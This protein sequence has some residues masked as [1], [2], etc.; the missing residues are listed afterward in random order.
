MNHLFART[1]G[2]HIAA[3][4][5]TMLTS[6]AFSQPSNIDPV[7]KHSWSENVGWMNWADAGD[8][9]RA[10]GVY[11]FATFGSSA[12]AGY[13]WGENIGWV[14]FGDGSPTDGVSY[15]NTDSSDFGV[16]RDPFTGEL[17]GYAWSENVGWINFS[18]GAGASPPQPA[19]FVF[20][21]RRFRG[22]AWGENI[23]WINLD[24]PS[25]FVGL[26]CIADVNS[27]E[28]VDAIDYDT[29]VNA[30][31]LGV[32]LGDINLDGFVDAID[33]DTFINAWLNGC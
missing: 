21:D 20:E 6:L 18:G 17:S 3:A 2:R 12:L 31:L 27:D 23:G 1:A 8:P 29:F 19:R 11:V 30:W 15:S 7:K 28:F 5:S 32:P 10:S 33:Y 14:R 16:N 22:Y 4:G 26:G 9:P 24:S 25:G 13:A